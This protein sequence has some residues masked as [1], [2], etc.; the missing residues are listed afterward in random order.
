MNANELFRAG[1]LAEAIRTLGD[2]L[3]NN[4]VDTQRRTFLFE[5]LCFAGDYERAEKQLDVLAERGKNAEL[6]AMLYRSALHAERERHLLFEAK[7]YLNHAETPADERGG[8]LNG[9]PFRS[10]ADCDP[11]VGGRLEVFV[12]GKYMWIPFAEIASLEMQAPKRLRDL[13]WPPVVLRAGPQFQDKELGEVLVPALAPFSWKHKDDAVRLGRASVW[14]TG[15]GNEEIP[16]GQKMLLVD[17]EEVPIL[18]IR[19]L[20]FTKAAAVA[21]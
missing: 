6:G 9:K 15:D 21:S 5:L 18:E 16:Y 2:E 8:T 14:E 11:R 13:L 12:A 17:D 19:K 20:E 10:I 4:P 1:K 3:R 7:E